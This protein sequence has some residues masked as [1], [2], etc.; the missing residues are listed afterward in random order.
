MALNRL[1]V[2]IESSAIEQRSWLKEVRAIV[3]PVRETVEDGEE[4]T[5]D[6]G[7]EYDDEDD[8]D[9]SDVLSEFNIDGDDEHEA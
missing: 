2:A 7:D 9:Y 3:K 4:Y 5:V 1:A 8:E 6:D